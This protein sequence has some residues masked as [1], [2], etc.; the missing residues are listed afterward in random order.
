MVRG[1]RFGGWSVRREREK[2]RGMNM[3]K[4]VEEREDARSR[5]AC[6]RSKDEML[7]MA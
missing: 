2:E 7:V 6:K 3:R 5:H 4:G 1:G